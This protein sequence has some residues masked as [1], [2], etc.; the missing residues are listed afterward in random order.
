MNFGENKNVF[1]RYST[2]NWVSYFD[3]PAT[4]LE[5]PDH[6]YDIYSFDIDVPANKVSLIL[7]KLEK[8]KIA[9]NF[10]KK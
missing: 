2:D 9:E 10:Y 8:F 4:F 5:A 7:K 6:I 1:V 3:C